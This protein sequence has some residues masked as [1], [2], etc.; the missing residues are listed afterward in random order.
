MRN[1][2]GFAVLAAA[3]AFAAP[4]GAATVTTLQNGGS[5][6]P[7]DGDQFN[8]SYISAGGAGN[9]SADFTPNPASD[10]IGVIGINRID[11]GNFFSV[12][13]GWKDAIGDIISSQSVN[14][15]F[16]L[17]Q[18][19]FNAGEKQ[20]FFFNFLDSKPGGKIDA[21]VMFESAPATVSPVP[22]P[23]AGLLLLAALGSVAA[24]GRKKA[25]VPVGNANFAMA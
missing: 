23:A 8:I 11:L 10:A 9:F 7:G 18:T 20:T 25:K 19:A 16:T 5:Y 1:T 13:V 22:I 2:V 17:A 15:T 24:F 3:L 6:T 12:V 21:N 14:S 4:V